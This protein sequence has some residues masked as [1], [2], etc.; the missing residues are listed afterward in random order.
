MSNKKR[1]IFILATTFL[2]TVFSAYVFKNVLLR[3]TFNA[4]NCLTVGFTLLAIFKTFQLIFNEFKRYK[5]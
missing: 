2:V 4:T 3:K 5:K 1:I